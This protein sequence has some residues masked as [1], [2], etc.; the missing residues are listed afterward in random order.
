MQKFRT[1]IYQNEEMINNIINQIKDLRNI[2]KGEKTEINSKTVGGANVGI[3]K[4][5]G[6]LTGTMKTKYESRQ[7]DVEDFVSWCEDRGN[8]LNLNSQIPKYEDKGIIIIASGKFYLPEKIQDIELIQSVMRNE[9]LLATMPGNNEEIKKILRGSEKIPMLLDLP[10]DLILNCQIIKK[11]LKEGVDNF[12]ED[13][14]DECTIIAKMDN[15]YENGSV[16]IFDIA[17]EIL[18]VNRT[19]RRKMTSEQLKDVIVYEE[20]PLI[21]VTPLIIY[22]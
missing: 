6:N 18:K 3:A 13:M 10:N 8:S 11:H 22:K 5:E 17:K 1:Y 4:L 2:K 9:E 7:N 21:K 15:L 12:L 16:E 14:E 20:A 19:V